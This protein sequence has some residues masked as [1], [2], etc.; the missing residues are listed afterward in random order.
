M[1][2]LEK[3]QALKRGQVFIPCTMYMCV[4]IWQHGHVEII[5]NDQ[6]NRITPYVAFND[7][8]RLIRDAAKNQVA[9]NPINTVFGMLIKLFIILCLFRFQGLLIYQHFC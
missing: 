6:R 7:T 1:V 3:E 8:K 5:G 2:F 4:G 9:A